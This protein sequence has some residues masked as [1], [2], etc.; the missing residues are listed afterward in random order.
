MSALPEFVDLDAALALRVKTSAGRLFIMAAIGFMLWKIGGWSF[1]AEW[2]T[3]YA[4]LQV[5]MA[6]AH[7]LSGAAGAFANYG[8]AIATYAVAGFPAWHLWTQDGKLGIA[9]ATMFLCGMLVQLVVSSLGARILFWVSAAPLTGY[10]IAIPPLAFGSTRLVEGLAASSCG[11]LFVGYLSLL[12]LGQQ[13]ALDQLR[14]SRRSAEVAQRRAE[15]ANQAKTDFLAAMSH[16]LRTPMNAVLGAADLLGRTRLDEEQ[17]AHLALLTDGGAILMHVLNDVLDLSKIEAGKLEIDP[18]AVDVHDFARRCAALWAPRARD[19]GLDFQLDIASSVPRYVEIDGARVGQIV[20]NLLS[21]ALKFT[22]DGKVSLSLDAIEVNINQTE[23]VFSV[24]D[25]GIGMSPEA[26]SRLFT[27]FEQA[28]GSISRRFGGTGLG[29]SISQ[30]LAGMMDGSISVE[31]VEGLGSTF[32]LRMPATP[33]EAPAMRGSGLPVDDQDLGP[34]MRILVAEDNPSNQRI[35]ELF[36]K[37]IGAHV[38]IVE[39]GQQALD[40]LEVAAFDLV[41]MD[42]QMPVMDGLEA[43]RRLRRSNGINAGIPVIALTANVMAAHRR[44]C[45]EAG[46]NGHVSKPIDARMLLATVINASVDPDSFQQS[47][48]AS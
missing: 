11:V 5:A 4:V 34:S 2:W 33:C 18:T 44:A 38:T 15:E 41:L 46:M 19:K 6:F 47:A 31:S 43:T 30:R 9:A 14:E 23:L 35:I 13:R 37:P 39:D 8:L 40:A 26:R 36:L 12:W 45:L 22:S 32:L 7:R 21:N 3:I 48:L 29:L 28:D 27:A 10:L 25:S 1:A 20:F 17:S 16:E 24:S 42:L